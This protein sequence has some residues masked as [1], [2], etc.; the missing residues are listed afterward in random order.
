MVGP[1][2]APTENSGLPSLSTIVGLIL[3][4]GRLPGPTEFA[5]APTTPKKLA[6][7]GGIAKSSIW[8]FRI[9]PV[10]GITTLEPNE[11]LIFAVHATQFPSPSAWRKCCRGLP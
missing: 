5:S 7:P 6:T 4:R 11:G 2:A 3:E 1:P 10:P 9:T 8:L